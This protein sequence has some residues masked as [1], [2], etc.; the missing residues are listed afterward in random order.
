M[1]NKYHLV[2]FHNG[3]IWL[4]LKPWPKKNA[5]LFTSHSGHSLSQSRVTYFHHW[6]DIFG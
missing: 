3:Q 6:D 4:I 2:N 5:T 1:K